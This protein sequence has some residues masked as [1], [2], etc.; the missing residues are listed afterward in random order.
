M[1]AWTSSPASQNN[2][3]R[4]WIYCQESYFYPAWKGWSG[5]CRNFK[6]LPSEPECHEDWRDWWDWWDWH[7]IFFFF[8]PWP[9]APRRSWRKVWRSKSMSSARR[10]LHATAASASASPKLGLHAHVKQRKKGFRSMDVFFWCFFCQDFGWIKRIFIVFFG[11]LFW[12]YY[13]SLGFSRFFPTV[14]QP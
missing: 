9:I 5:S 12:T 1:M 6:K 3:Q 13:P 2:G 11:C 14:R 7:S 8:A 4:G 10:T